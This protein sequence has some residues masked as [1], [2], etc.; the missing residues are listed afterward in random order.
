[1]NYHLPHLGRGNFD[2]DGV[3]GKFHERAIVLIDSLFG[4]RI[5]IDQFTEW[6]VSSVLPEQAMKDLLN[7][8]LASPGYASS[9]EPYPEA[10]AAMLELRAVLEEVRFVTAPHIKSM[11]WMQE[12]RD[13]LVDKFSAAHE[14][15]IHI[16]L[17][18]EVAGGLLL[19]DR[20]KTVRRWQQAHPYGVGLLMDRPYNR[21][22][23]ADGLRRVRSWDE[24]IE[25]AK[26]LRRQ[27]G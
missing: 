4:I 25:V 14:E 24:V 1:M 19:E 9:I 27:N 11:T 16:H 10:Q 12:R 17:K 3:C 13:W 2:V 8:N 20:P 5:D 23:D 6:D 15:I 21:G 26:T 7:A 22:A 18:H